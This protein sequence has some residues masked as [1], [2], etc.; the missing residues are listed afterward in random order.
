MIHIGYYTDNN[1]SH[2]VMK[3]F[4]RSGIIVTHIKNFRPD[5][6]P[7]F[8]GILRGCGTA[9]RLMQHLKK[10]Y[11]YVDNGYF[12]AH[13]MDLNKRKEMSGKYRIVKNAKI[14]TMCINPKKTSTEKLRVLILPPS[15][16]TAFMH[17]TIPE[18]WNVESIKRIQAAGHSHHVRNKDEQ[19]T[20]RKQ[21]SDFD[22]VYAFNSMGVV[23]A[24]ELGKAVYT[25]HGIIRN[26]DLME[27]GAAPYYD[28][29]EI[30]K[31][32]DSKQFTLEEIAD[33]GVKCLI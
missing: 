23:E 7:I 9:M 31:F 3:A 11:Y 32:Y 14:E 27:I 12:D 18:D 8:Y 30:R 1:V 26:R 15:P 20:L 19:R 4:S 29:D 13:Y 5:L 10:D 28:I 16:Y 21:L 24:I 25:T 22:A 33:R 2:S 6:T 17:D